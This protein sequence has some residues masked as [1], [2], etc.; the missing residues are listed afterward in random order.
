MEQPLISTYLEEERMAFA[1]SWSG[2]QQE[3]RDAIVFRLAVLRYYQ[4]LRWEQLAIRLLGNSAEEFSK[5]VPP[6]AYLEPQGSFY[7]VIDIAEGASLYSAGQEVQVCEQCYLLP[8]RHIDIQLDSKQKELEMELQ[9]HKESNA[10][11]IRFFLQVDSQ[12]DWEWIQALQTMCQ[13]NIEW[14]DAQG[15]ERLKVLPRDKCLIIPSKSPKSWNRLA[16]RDPH[17]R[18]EFHFR[19]PIE[20]ERW[21]NLRFTFQVN[22]FPCGRLP[23]IHWNYIRVNLVAR[24]TLPWRCQKGTGH[25]S[26]PITSI[27][28]GVN[29][30]YSLPSQR[31]VVMKRI[32]A[33]FHEFASHQYFI[34]TLDESLEGEFLA[35]VLLEYKQREEVFWDYNGATSLRFKRSSDVY[36]GIKGLHGASLFQALAEPTCIPSTIS[37][38]TQEYISWH[39]R[40][41]RIRSLYD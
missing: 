30:V 1:G 40:L 34:D 4:D 39:T 41:D 22:Q 32:G 11:E 8:I 6:M 36:E 38:K 9:L 10:N 12:L 5:D 26:L 7:S 20:C 19:L 14:T 17:Y 31:S 27:C 24:E 13:V 37:S 23:K 33:G 25:I 28:W 35:E 29:E 18:S 16:I 2:I 21:Q 3:L 15:K